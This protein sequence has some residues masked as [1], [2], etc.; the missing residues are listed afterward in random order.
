MSGTA[1]A[2]AG[3]AAAIQAVADA[4][5]AATTDPGDG[6]RLLLQ[7][8]GAASP[9]NAS[10]LGVAAAARCRRAA[11]IAACGQSAQ[12]QPSSA[13]DAQ[14]MVARLGQALDAEITTAGDAGDDAAYAA[15]LAL[16]AAVVTD[17]SV[18]GAS[19]A[20]LVDVALPGVTNTLALANQLYQDASRE[21]ELERR[22]DPIHPLFV[23]G[24][25]QVLAR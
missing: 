2:A 21:D 18:R 13:D 20:P 11:L 14:A 3:V 24:T 15:L 4:V 23:N 10:P 25:V 9:A 8:A 22:L 1:S 6:I 5:G 7:L 12:W 17:L 16:R 19:L